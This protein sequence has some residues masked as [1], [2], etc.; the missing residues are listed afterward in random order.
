MSI[1]IL[2]RTLTEI[3]HKK[4]ASNLAQFLAN[5]GIEHLKHS[6]LMLSTLNSHVIQHVFSNPELPLPSCLDLF[7]FLR[8]NPARKPD[9]V[10]HMTLIYRLYGAQK[11]NEVEFVLKCI[12]NDV[13]LRT[14]VPNMVSL[15]KDGTDDPIFVETLCG[16]L[17]RIY[18]S[19]GMFEEA[20]G[21]FDY[22]EK[23]GFKI[24]GSSFYDDCD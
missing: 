1:H 20:I 2:I 21:V 18:A 17:F 7:N 11:F 19:K 5:S 22:M 15:V 12:A 4:T 8:E 16:M 10:A 6:P 14:S 3:Q 9:L 23:S 13:N 24:H